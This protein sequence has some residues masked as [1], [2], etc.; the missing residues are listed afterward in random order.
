MIQSLGTKR[1]VTVR[2]SIIKDKF[3]GISIGK[4]HDVANLFKVNGF[5]LINYCDDRNDANKIKRVFD[6]EVESF[7]PSNYLTYEIDIDGIKFLDGMR[8]V[9]FLEYKHCYMGDLYQKKHF[10]WE[11]EDVDGEWISDGAVQSKVASILENADSTIQALV[12]NFSAHSDFTLPH[13]FFYDDGNRVP[14]WKVMAKGKGSIWFVIHTYNLKSFSVV[15][16]TNSKFVRKYT[17]LSQDAKCK[18]ENAY[19][20]IKAFKNELRD[21]GGILRPCFSQFTY[22]LLVLY[23]LGLWDELI[24]YILNGIND[25]YVKL[26]NQMDKDLM[27]GLR[28][29]L[30][31]DNCDSKAEY[32]GAKNIFKHRMVGLFEILT[33]LINAENIKNNTDRYEAFCD[34]MENGVF[35][36]IEFLDRIRNQS[37]K[38]NRSISILDNYL[39]S[40]NW[41]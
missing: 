15:S 22:N 40:N 31:S 18:E 9:I 35:G 7:I 21:I 33:E 24:D 26:T 5:K 25:G 1:Q 37:G 29:A 19:P 6:I 27:E 17:K 32:E 30:S 16:F 4:L 3:R 13:P 38:G 28:D 8:P 36:W 41:I 12:D 20:I 23:R 39:K 34:S 2:E 10:S 11:G 14:R